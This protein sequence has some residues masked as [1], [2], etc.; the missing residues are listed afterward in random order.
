MLPY[1]DIQLE[2]YK[3][4]HINVKRKILHLYQQMNLSDKFGEATFGETGKKNPSTINTENFASIRGF[5]ENLTI[6]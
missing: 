4:R 1:N 6:L 3:L 2:L 5:F